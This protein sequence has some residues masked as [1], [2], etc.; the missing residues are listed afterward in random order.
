MLDSDGNVIPVKDRLAA[1]VHALVLKAMV[2]TFGG[3]RTCGHEAEKLTPVTGKICHCNCGASFTVPCQ[4]TRVKE[5]M[6]R[7]WQCVDCGENRTVS[8]AGRARE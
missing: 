5:L 2:W 1:T 3:R 7:F 6:P 4:H 8:G